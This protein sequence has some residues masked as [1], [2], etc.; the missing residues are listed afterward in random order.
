MSRAPVA[1][2]CRVVAPLA[3][4]VLLGSACGT[5]TGLNDLEADPTFAGKGESGG[6]AGNGGSA[7]AA[8]NGGSAG[9]AGNAGTGGMSGGGS[10]GTGGIM[11]EVPEGC[12]AVPSVENVSMVLMVARGM[13][14][15]VRTNVKNAVLEESAPWTKAQIA[16]DILPQENTQ[17]CGDALGSGHPIVGPALASSGSF[18]TDAAQ[19][20]QTLS[21]APGKS[22]SPELSLRYAQRTFE[23]HPEYEAKAAIL[24]TDEQEEG[25]DFSWAETQATANFMIRNPPFARTYAT[26]FS[27]LID[28]TAVLVELGGTL[29][30]QG[31][32][33]DIS[34][35]LGLIY[36]ELH[37]CTLHFD[38]TTQAELAMNGRR[39]LFT[40]NM[41]QC[42]FN[43]D[44]G[45][46]AAGDG[47]INLC[48]FTCNKLVQDRRA[49]DP[50]AVIAYCPD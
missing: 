25:C 18:R 24:I 50:K 4:L 5:I 13:S 15:V 23:Q 46:Y 27:N 31:V 1:A 32:S 44:D 9:S 6:A 14:S 2:R 45:Y 40:P 7:G 35:M 37:D 34:D 8:G 49:E 21:A 30:L 3:A 39:V 17:S 19:F 48:P 28:Y 10:G 43:Q 38:H 41:D 36:Q 26:A 20:F 47:L 11:W 16:L 42:A 12:D 33:A 22:D 29:P